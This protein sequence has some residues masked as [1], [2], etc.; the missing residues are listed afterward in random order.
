MCSLMHQFW[1]PDAHFKIQA[2]ERK[3]SIKHSFNKLHEIK[4]VLSKYPHT[5]PENES[6]LNKTR[7]EKKKNT[8]KTKSKMKPVKLTQDRKGS[9]LV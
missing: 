7:K 4:L 3:M 6:T 5:Y 1:F 2:G 8:P 9:P